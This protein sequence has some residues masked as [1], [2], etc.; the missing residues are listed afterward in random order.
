[1]SLSIIGITMGDPVGIGPEIIVKALAQTEVFTSCKPLVFG[2]ANVLK[3]ANR[4]LNS[5]CTI[6]PVRTAEEAKGT[7]GMVD[8]IELSHIDLNG[9]RFG[10]PKKP[11]AALIVRYLETALSFAMDG[12]IEG[13]TTCPI[14][15]GF[16]NDAGYLF[17]GHTEFLAQRTNSAPVTMMLITPGLKVALVTTHCAMRDVPGLL[18][19]ERIMDTI[20]VTDYALRTSFGIRNPILAVASLNPHA[21]ED[22]LFGDEEKSS[23]LPAIDECRRAGF[24]VEGPMASDSLFHFAGEGIYDA[25][26]CMYHDQGLIPI[27]LMGFKRSV[28]VTLGLPIIRTSVDHGTAYDIAGRGVADPSSLI[29]AIILASRMAGEKGKNI[30]NPA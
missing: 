27:K 25:V 23:I 14:N 5:P 18:T 3:E 16:L 24:N 19:P 4:V 12:R 1:M 10:T 15:K 2:D 17:T 13:M 26:V 20:R 30:D 29:E 11:Y 21:G 8:L 28:N 9:F 22:G 7:P 6:N